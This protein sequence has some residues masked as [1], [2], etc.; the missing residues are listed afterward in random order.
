MTL[1]IFFGALNAI[2]QLS[3]IKDDIHIVSKFRCLLGHRVFYQY[4][5]MDEQSLY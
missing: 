2:Y 3:E 4:I 1:N 5:Q